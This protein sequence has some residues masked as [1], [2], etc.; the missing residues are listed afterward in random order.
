MHKLRFF[1]EDKTRVETDEQDVSKGLRLPN[2]ADPGFIQ[3]WDKQTGQWA[4][5]DGKYYA[6]N[7]APASQLDRIESKIDFLL[8]QAIPFL[9]ATIQVTSN[10]ILTGTRS[11]GSSDE[12]YKL[13][14]AYQDACQKVEELCTG[15]QL[16]MEALYPDAIIPVESDDDKKEVAMSIDTPREDEEVGEGT[17]AETESEDETED[18]QDGDGD[19]E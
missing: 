3:I 10:V 19:E 16:L 1:S 2:W 6:Q 9:Q 4:V 17:E 12:A 14:G 15:F 5:L 8:T 11:A 7:I 18:E 13:Q